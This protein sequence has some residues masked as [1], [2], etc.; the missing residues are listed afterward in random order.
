MEPV[1][2]PIT[3]TELGI[4]YPEWQKAY[5]DALLE[6]DLGKLP[7]RIRAAEGA[8][9]ARQRAINGSLD[10]HRAERQAIE[11]ALALLRILAKGR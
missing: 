6:L 8:I 4:R 5:E 1:S 10:D 3:N 11:D 7:E 9:L 2:S